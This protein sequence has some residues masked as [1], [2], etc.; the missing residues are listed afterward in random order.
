MT[1]ERSDKTHYFYCNSRNFRTDDEDYNRLRATALR[2]AFE[3]E[4]KPMIEAQQRSIGNED[5]LK[6]RPALLPVDV[7][8]VR[9]RRLYNKDRTPSWRE[10][11]ALEP[12]GK[13]GFK[14]R[15][16]DN[17]HGPCVRFQEAS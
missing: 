13:G 1:P 6:L 9:A 7:G 14:R 10:R 17:V 3:L 15:P 11:F 12:D 8:S 5:L 4:D 16:R 2:R